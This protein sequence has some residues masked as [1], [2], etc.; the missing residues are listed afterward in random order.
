MTPEMP[1]VTLL[2]TAMEVILHQPRFCTTRP[3]RAPYAK[4]PDLRVLPAL[5]GLGRHSSK[6][7]IKKRSLVITVTSHAPRWR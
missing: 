1:M 6:G 5:V 2:W 4:S 7:P 3:F